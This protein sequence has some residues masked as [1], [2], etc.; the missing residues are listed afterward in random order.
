MEEEKN[1]K[2][3]FIDKFVLGALIG[4]AIGS[5]IGLAFAPKPGKETR[6]DIKNKANGLYEKYIRDKDEIKKEKHTIAGH[7]QREKSVK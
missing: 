1:N 6:K 3:T 2:K 5:V 4:G 7:I